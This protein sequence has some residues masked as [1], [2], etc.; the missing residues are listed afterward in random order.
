MI[1]KNKLLKKIGLNLVSSKFK[2]Y[3]FNKFLTISI[4]YLFSV[5]KLYLMSSSKN[6]L[7]V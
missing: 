5:I 7:S 2:V 3:T 6:K 1:D 4:I